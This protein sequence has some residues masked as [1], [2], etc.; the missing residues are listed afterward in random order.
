MQERTKNWKV[1]ID[2]KVRK[3]GGRGDDS[4]YCNSDDIISEN[5]KNV[6]IICSDFWQMLKYRSWKF[7]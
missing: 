1:F 2:N 4:E 6:P 3:W 5:G 7:T